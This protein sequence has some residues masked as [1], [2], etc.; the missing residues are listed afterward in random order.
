MGLR[1][2]LG[3]HR[4]AFKIVDASLGLFGH[5][6]VF[7]GRDLCGFFKV[8]SSI[9]NSILALGHRGSAKE[10]CE[11]HR[12]SS[13]SASTPGKFGGAGEERIGFREA[14]GFFFVTQLGA[15]VSRGEAGA[16][17]GLDRIQE[18]ITGRQHREFRDGI[19]FRMRFSD[20]SEGS[21]TRGGG[22]FGPSGVPS[23]ILSSIPPIPREE[24]ARDQEQ[25][26]QIVHARCLEP[27]D[28]LVVEAGIGQISGLNLLETIVHD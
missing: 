26:E 12:L 18:E 22:Q 17:S 10:G 2:K 1:R 21:G 7:R 19:D 27:G 3:V 13:E 20:A 16:E 8:L 11:D 14:L 15:L 24:R 9:V 5:G 25:H 6:C 4:K 28:K 23:L